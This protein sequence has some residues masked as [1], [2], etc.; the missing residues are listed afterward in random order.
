MTE[1]LFSYGTLQQPKVQLATF[2]RK[3][4]GR[5]DAIVGYELDYLVIT[6]PHVVATSGSDRRGGRLTAHRGAA[7][8]GCHGVGLR[9]RG[10]DHQGRV[11]Q[12]TPVVACWVTTTW[13]S[14]AISQR[15]SGVLPEPQSG[16]W[17]PP[18]AVTIAHWFGFA[19]VVV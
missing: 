11:E 17:H 8:V 3:L 1:L 19:S 14:T 4:T 9:L 5:R 12:V 10:S 13:P 18:L 15:S 6:D 7:A 16:Q 2:A